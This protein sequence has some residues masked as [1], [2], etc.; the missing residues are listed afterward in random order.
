MPLFRALGAVVSINDIAGREF[1]WYA[2]DAS[3]AMAVFATAGSGFVPPSVLADIES[4]D[5]ISEAIDTPNW[6][7]NLVW[8]DYANA[9]LFVF[10]WKL[11]QGPYA[12]L[13][14]PHNSISERLLERLRSIDSL[15][16]FA[17]RFDT[18]DQIEESV[19]WRGT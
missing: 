9:G 17:G 7:S 18:T 19:G 10:D 4:Y 3:G 5:R 2:V 11:Y 13:R 14:V 12:R 16:S 15:P 1:D 6:G 8:D